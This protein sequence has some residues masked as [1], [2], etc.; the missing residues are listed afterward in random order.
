MSIPGPPHIE[1]P[2]CAGPHLARVR[3]RQQRVVQ[4]GEDAARALVALDRQ[5]G[6]GDVADEQ[7]VAGQHRPRLVAAAAVDE[8]ERGVLGP[9]AGR[10]QRADDDVAELE[11]P[12][13]VERLVVVL[14]R[15]EA[16]DVD[17]R[18]G[19][20]RQPAVAGDVI[21][22]VVR[23]EDVLDADTHVPCK[24]QI[25]IDLEARIDDGGDSRAVVADEVGRAAEIVVGDLAKQHARD[26]T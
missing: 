24:V 13:V 1:P 7:R 10:V 22:V 15:G 21:G 6:P 19:G 12:A 16:V 8:R 9:V 23:L 3:Q 20:E 11:L 26:D 14:G 4:A 18:A 5:V 2:R 25:D 17:R